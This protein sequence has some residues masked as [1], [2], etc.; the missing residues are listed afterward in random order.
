MM[1]NSRKYFRIMGVA[2]STRGFGFAVLDGDKL[3][4]WG[5]KM[6]S[7]DK[8]A[9]T[10]LKLDELMKHYQ[11]KALVIEDYHSKNSHRAPR[12]MVRGRRIEDMAKRHKVRLISYSRQ[13]IRKVFFADGSGNKDAIA[14]IL[15]KRF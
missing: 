9:Q 13:E 10:L 7:G 2:P 6:V 4:N 8:N 15:A 14:E 11:P 1:Q 3:V 5:V 12:I